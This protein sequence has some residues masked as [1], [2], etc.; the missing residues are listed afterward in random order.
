MFSAF[1]IDE[2]GRTWFFKVMPVDALQN[3]TLTPMMRQYWEI[4]SQHP[5][6]ILFYR[7]G[8]FY[9]MF[10]DDAIEA[11]RRLDLTLTTRNKNQENS[12]PLCGIPHHAASGYLAKLVAQGC[13][14]VICDQVE[15]PKM[16]KGIVKR[17]VTRIVSPGMLLDEQAL[18]GKSGNFMVAVAGKSPDFALAICDVSTGF[19]EYTSVKTLS[20]MGDEIRRLG[21]KEVI[22]PEAWR[23][24]L[25]ESL[26]GDLEG[27]YCHTAADL[28]FD[29][30]Y[31][32]DKIKASFG[33]SSPLILGFDV[34]DA[35]SI[36]ALGGLLGAL[37]EGKILAPGLLSQPLKRVDGSYLRLDEACVRNLELFKSSRD[38]SLRGTLFW[39]LDVC[40]TVMGSRR[41]AMWLRMPLTDLAMIQAR[42]EAVEFLLEQRP[43]ATQFGEILAAIGDLERM[44]NRFVAGSGHARDAAGL[45]EALEKLP[46]LQSTLRTCQD[47]HLLSKLM[48]PDL[49]ELHKTL[50]QTLVDDV[51]L[52][53]KEGRIIR[54]G[55]SPE[56]D[57]L[58]EIE[59]NGKGY[60]AQLEGREKEASGISSLKIRY[61]AVFG[62]YIEITN[63]HKDKVPAGYIRK[64]TLANA[65]RYITAE[66]KDYEN[67][68]LGASERIKALEYEL[69]CRLRDKIRENVE[70]LKQ[71]ADAIATLDVLL[72]F[73]DSAERFHYHKPAMTDEIILQLK[74]ARH[75]V[76]EH[77][78][79][80][81]SFV[82]NDLS[83]DQ[84]GCVELIITGPN[85]AGK[86][87]LMRMAALI[88]VMGQVGAFV[89][90][91]SA[92]I[93]ICDRIFTRVGAHDHL[94]KG[95]STFMVEMV[96]TAKILREATPR[97]FILLDEIGRGT[98][99]F[100]GLSIAWAV[101]EDIHDR[102]KAR[103]LFATHYHE[104]CDL[105]EQRR[106]IKNAHMAVK[107]WNGEILFLRKLR[108]G[109]TNR[110]YGVAVASMAGLP[111]STIKR[112]KEILSL[113]EVKDLSFKEQ[114]NSDSVKNQLT[115]FAV[116][117]S[118]VLV[119]LNELDPNTLTPL[120]ALMF[121]SQLK[122]LAQSQS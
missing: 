4:K 102:L 13:K 42:Q 35:A 55:V 108:D 45:R 100:D 72:A 7:L 67:K 71:A 58:R 61:N 96:E 90:C 119:A 104:L 78:N 20:M 65:E 73:A 40:R 19:L 117:P 54:F 1:L 70:A 107:D 76:L 87:T 105:A 74:G 97:S 86:S 114:T 83:L 48:W 84:T 15:D 116:P 17:E 53:L 31:A 106:G 43:R 32:A 110:S 26:R 9:E 52:S 122:A 99:T 120:D 6:A 12:V 121:L 94:Q 10:F 34:A 75:P 36:S 91:E 59:S 30:D 24:S 3:P 28:L 89:P 44:S 79:P 22:Y 63:T 88:I 21:A 98:S 41:L 25:G 118:P 46:I 81:E 39:H 33:V 113:L 77:L 16:A 82:P 38:D 50:C 95:L 11:S 29:A 23:G 60:I 111:T 27:V 92:L 47:S 62:Y 69:F 56:L 109:G 2:A 115:L 66:L 51:P 64:Q 85:M 103:T 8:D 18:E 37:E 68:V 14:V 101:A 5:D 80:G 49:T 57:E 93:G 112:A